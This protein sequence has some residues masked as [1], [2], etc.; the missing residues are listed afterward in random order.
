MTKTEIQIGRIDAVLY[1]TEDLLKRTNDKE[2][3]QMAMETAYDH[4]KGIVEDVEWYPWK[5]E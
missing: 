4:I 2:T 3:R 5:G 1:A